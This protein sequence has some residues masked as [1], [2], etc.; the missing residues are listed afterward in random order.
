MSLGAEIVAIASRKSAQLVPI[1]CVSTSPFEVSIFGMDSS[2]PARKM[3]GS[4]FGLG[5][6]GM[7][8]WQPPLPPYCFITS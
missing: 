6:K 8:F 4:T 3:A 1:T 2:I 5:D 7:A